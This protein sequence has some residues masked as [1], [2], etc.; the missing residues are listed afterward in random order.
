MELLQ[1]WRGAAKTGTAKQLFGFRE[2]MEAVVD[3]HRGAHLAIRRPE[4]RHAPDAAYDD[5]LGLRAIVLLLRKGIEVATS[6]YRSTQLAPAPSDATVTG[7][8]P[9]GF[10][11]GRDGDLAGAI[12]AALTALGR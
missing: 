3:T 5:K 1:P 12:T 8:L 10:S 6:E 9:S 4:R 11:S 2:Q 7:Y